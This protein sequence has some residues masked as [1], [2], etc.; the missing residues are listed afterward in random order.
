MSKFLKICNLSV[1][2]LLIFVS[3][4]GKTTQKVL[5][6]EKLILKSPHS[7]STIVLG[8]Q[9]EIPQILINEGGNTVFQIEGGNQPSVSL[10][11]SGKTLAKII[12]TKEASEFSLSD[13]NGTERLS[14]KVGS[15]PGVFLKNPENKIIGTWTVLSDGGTGLGLADHSGSAASIL[16]GGQSPSVSFFTSQNEPMAAFGMIQKV[17]H[18]LISGPEGNEG[19]LIHGG[20]P[21][22]MVFVDE[23]GKVKILISKHGVFQEKEQSAP[24]IQKKNEKVFSLED[25]ELLFPEIPQK[26]VR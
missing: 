17:P 12:A 23:V 14:M 25:Q 7:K 9:N 13:V 15:T 8:F 10:K 1:L 11:D 4:S 18:L 26:K 6:V 16:R 2:L 22:S 3:F 5:E 20:K 21:S 19:I 24:P